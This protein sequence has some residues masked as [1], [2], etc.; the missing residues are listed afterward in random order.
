[1][2]WLLINAGEELRGASSCLASPWQ[3][4]YVPHAEIAALE[5]GGS[6]VKQAGWLPAM[7]CS[8]EPLLLL[9]IALDSI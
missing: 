9:P 3:S 1:M 5:D 2:A 8:S 6:P 7:H 4:S